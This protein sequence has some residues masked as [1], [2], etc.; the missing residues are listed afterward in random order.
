MDKNKMNI[1]MIEDYLNSILDNVVSKNTFFGYMPEKETID[2]S[3]TDM[4]FIELPNGIRDNMAYGQGTAL[5]WLYA[6][7]LSSGRKNV[8]KM[9]ELEVK[10]NEVLATASHPTYTISRRAT[11]TDYDTNIN[12]HCNAVEVIVKVY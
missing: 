5:V 8:A 11:Y 6:R 2:S 1:S 4:V 12:W 9:N 3:W 10:L 7:P